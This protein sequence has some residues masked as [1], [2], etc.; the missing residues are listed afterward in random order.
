MEECFWHLVQRGK[1]TRVL[2]P[3]RA[4]ILGLVRPIIEAP[5]HPEITAFD[6]DTGSEG[7]GIRTYLW[8][9]EEDYLV[10]LRRYPRRY[11]MVTT[12]CI[13]ER[14]EWLRKDLERRFEGLIN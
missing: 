12:F 2:D 7:K 4:E 11:A 6:Y 14:D 1:G 5:S 3:H 13:D 9:R 10:I 8:L